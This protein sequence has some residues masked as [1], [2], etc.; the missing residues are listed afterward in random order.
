MVDHTFRP[1]L[2]CS[3]SRDELEM[4]QVLL[5]SEGIPCS[6]SVCVGDGRQVL[7]VFLG[8]EGVIAPLELR[9]QNGEAWL[10]VAREDASAA[11]VLVSRSSRGQN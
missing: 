10:F 11:Y 7:D 8:T 6:V 3:G 5:E 9:G 4:I 1:T 2:V